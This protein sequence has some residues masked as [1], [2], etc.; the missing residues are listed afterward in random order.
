MC[1]SQNSYEQLV[2]FHTISYSSLTSRHLETKA[3]TADHLCFNRVTVLSLASHHVLDT[4][5]PK[6]ALPR[7]GKLFDTKNID[8]GPLFIGSTSGM[9]VH[10]YLFLL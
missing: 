6:P 3:S 1:F 4:Y 9:P 8:A 2:L 10:A 7:A 5:L